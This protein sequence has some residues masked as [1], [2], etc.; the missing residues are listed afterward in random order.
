MTDRKGVVIVG[1]LSD[2]NLAPIT[3]E[4]LG[5]GRKL[6]DDWGQELSAVFIGSGIGQAAG[7]AVFFGADKV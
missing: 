3:T 1:E 4:L 5:I 7:E 6:A 2:D